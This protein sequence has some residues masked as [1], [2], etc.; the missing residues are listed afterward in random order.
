MYSSPSQMP[1]RTRFKF[2]VAKLEKYI[3]YIHYCDELAV[4]QVK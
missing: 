4:E 3:W 2:F 1:K